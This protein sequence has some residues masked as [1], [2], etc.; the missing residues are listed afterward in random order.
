MAPD[1]GA[2]LLPA[3][4]SKV[5]SVS[6]CGNLE[7]SFLSTFPSTKAGGDERRRQSRT[8]LYG[9]RKRLPAS[10]PATGAAFAGR[11][12]SR[13]CRRRSSPN[14]RRVNALTRRSSAAATRACRRSWSSTQGL[15][16]LFIV[17]IAGQRDFIRGHGYAQFAAVHLRTPLFVMRVTGVGC[18]AG[19]ALAVKRQNAQERAR[20]RAAPGKDSAGIAGYRCRTDTARLARSRGRSQS[21]LVDASAA[22][23]RPKV[24]PGWRKGS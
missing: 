9:Q 10:S 2:R 15:E 4:G 18:G 1:S 22:E 17:R 13:P 16:R 6:P 19:F 24:A 5:L 21:A 7:D 11:R 8:H 20:H 14:S 23:H 3:P 12:D